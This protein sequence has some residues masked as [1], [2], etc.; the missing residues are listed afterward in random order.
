MNHLFNM[1]VKQV[2]DYCGS[3][4]MPGKFSKSRSSTLL[5]TSTCVV[6]TSKCKRPETACAVRKLWAAR[7]RLSF[8]YSVWL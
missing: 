8:V 3:L 1:F 2:E 4:S 5:L 6:S 7:W